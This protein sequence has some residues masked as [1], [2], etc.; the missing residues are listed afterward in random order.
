MSVL[1]KPVIGKVVTRIICGGM[2][3]LASGV[4]MAALNMPTRTGSGL[5]SGVPARDAS[6]TVFKGI[7]FAAPPV[8]EL[9][10]KAPQAP[11]AWQGVRAA[12]QFGST[13]PQLMRNTVSG[14]E[15][16]LFLNVWTGANSA[17]ERRPVFVWVHGGRFIFG[18]GSQPLFDGEGLARKG[19]VVVTFNYRLGV[20][21]FL[22]TPE[23]S[24]ES[25]HNASGNYGLLDQIA[26]LQWVRKNIAAF[27]G[28]PDR[29]TIAGQSAGSGS[30][31]QL[32][33]SPLTKGLLH[34]AIAES[35]ARF[36]N[37]PEISG[38]ATSY[39]QLKGAEA[40]GVK[41]AQEHGAP[42]LKELRALTMEQLLVGNNANDE[43]YYGKPPPPLFRPVMD[44][45]VIPNTYR[46][47]MAS[48]AVNR[49]PMITGNN[50]DESG[51]MPQPNI[52]LVDFQNAAKQKYGAMV[53]EFF[54]LYPATTDAEAGQANN[55]AARD[56]S[57]VSSFLWANEWS[58]ATNRPVYAYFWTH[59]PPG[60]D[61]DRRGAYHESEIN[62]I[63][64]NLYATD[65]PWT[66]DDHKIADT[67]SSYWANF[68]TTGN[69]NGKQ[70]P[71][72]PVADAK[73]IVMQLGDAF[74]T[75]SVVDAVKLDFWKR[76][77]QT[78][79]AW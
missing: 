17:K 73:P 22:A 70:L 8:G 42:S 61:R 79:K 33:N 60:P 2:V 4:A 40:D 44:G 50:L 48:G 18:A 41:Y 11:S 63:F 59:A 19:L 25:G 39:R 12:D 23:L 10:W 77:F 15:D 47:A 75:M 78:Q 29:V 13:C 35:G 6:I 53:E 1:L 64:N 38:L 68:A 76:F 71:R 27:G 55:A 56:S 36:P 66:D 62:Y 49:V 43:A 54:K 3:M 69:P 34:R 45:W 24:Q 74:G 31:L 21:G 57:R 20:F 30:V 28:D 51:A 5:V 37:D 9:R 26:A 14:N 58:K 65:R 72:W 52:K 7:P 16:C 46:Q 67:M 32:V